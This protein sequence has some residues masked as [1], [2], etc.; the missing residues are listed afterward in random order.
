MVAMSEHAPPFSRKEYGGGH[1]SLDSQGTFLPSVTSILR[2]GVPKPAL[3][4]WAGEVTAVY[5]V[6]NWQKLSRLG[7]ASRY[8]AIRDARFAKNKAATLRGSQLHQ[9][10]EAIIQG[11]QYQ[12]PQDSLAQAQAYARFRDDWHVSPLAVERIVGSVEHGYAGTFDLLAM[13][14]EDPWLLDLK[15]NASGIYGETALQLAA[16]RNGDWAETPPILGRLQDPELQTGAV[17]LKPDGEYELIPITT[18]EPEF[19]AFLA[20]KELA[21][22]SKGSEHLIGS[23]L[24]LVEKEVMQ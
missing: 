19:R 15:T 20:A 17:W 4:N 11:K 1:I 10:A 13:L 12:I 18:G 16:Y 3:I 9:A 24:A 14:G 23:P 21:G 8:K 7:H 22:W 5:V 2:D 6:D